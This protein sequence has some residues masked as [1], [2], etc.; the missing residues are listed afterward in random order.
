MARK[1]KP[2]SPEGELAISVGFRVTSPFSPG[3]RTES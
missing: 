2:L 3:L 1:A